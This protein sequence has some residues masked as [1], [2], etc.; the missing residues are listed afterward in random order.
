M[1][2][3][4]EGFVAQTS[5]AAARFFID[6]F[7]PGP[8]AAAPDGYRVLTKLAYGPRGG[9]VAAY[10]AQAGTPQ[11]KLA[12]WVNAQ[13]A[14]AL[15]DDSACDARIAAG[16]FTTLG[17]S[18][19]Q[20]Y[21]DHVRNPASNSGQA[22]SRP[23]A[24]TECARLIRAVH[25]RRQLLERTVEFWH[26]HFNVLG[27]EFSIAPVF[28]HYDRDV[29]RAHALG[30]FR[31]MLEAVAK[32]H[33]MMQFLDNKSSRGASFNE[34]YARE[35]C[36]L[37][38]L[39]AE[40]YYPGNNPFLVPSDLQGNAAG[41]CDNDVYEAARAL[42]GWTLADG[43]WQFPHLDSGEFLYWDSWHD[44]A[45]KIFMRSFIPPDNPAGAM[46]DGRHVFDVLC[47][48]AGTARHICRK[49]IRRFIGDTPAPALLDSAAALWRSQWQAPDQITQVLRHILT[50]PEVLSR[51]GDKRKRP[52]EVAMH[53]LRACDASFAPRPFADW[54]PYGEF[55]TRLQQTGHGMFRWPTPDGYPEDAKKW[56]AVGVLAQ[57]WRL[58]S[59]LPEW[60]EPDGG[61]RP[62]LARIHATTL[63]ALPSP[64]SRSANAIVDLWLQRVH[65]IARPGPRRD[66]LVDFLRQ[67]AAADAPL[68]LV[69]DDT[70]GTTGEPL[71][72]GIWRQND[73]KRHKTIARLR[74]M[75]A[76]LFSQPEFFE[77]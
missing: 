47:Q 1:S 63:Q 58:L 15:I 21:A 54:S 49:L 76:L 34:N 16:N 68:D 25:S 4:M 22:R 6:G 8:P 64:S 9:E 40:N 44:R 28:V 70:N 17:K 29:I 27:W 37:H 59:R 67:N 23:A 71:H 46:A 48:H 66:Q 57:S 39:G 56:Q 75:V 11:Q 3:L 55:N 73:L 5:T 12:A 77:R 41:Y 72:E 42:T 36:E 13:L 35:L 31:Q 38:T 32:S 60:R 20:L 61:A 43:H 14:P 7:E 62:F 24:E 69:E 52:F 50:A 2:F 30:N 10:E 45:S 51:W 26:D 65:G 53:A 33:A 19:A 74:A 18:L